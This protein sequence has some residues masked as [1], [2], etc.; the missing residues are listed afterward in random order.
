LAGAHLND[1][2]PDVLL[3]ALS[4]SFYF[5]PANHRQAFLQTIGE[6]IQ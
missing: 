5:L 1:G 6:Q 2:D 4:R 3:H